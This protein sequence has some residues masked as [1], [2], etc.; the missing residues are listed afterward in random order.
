MRLA[1]LTLNGLDLTYSETVGA[2]AA[3]L[4]GGGVDAGFATETDRLRARLLAAASV[5]RTPDRAATDEATEIDTPFLDASG[6]ASGDQRASG[7]GETLVVPI[8]VR[9]GGAGLP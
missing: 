5:T 3:L 2:I 8:R 4:D 6:E 1:K 9:E 7:V